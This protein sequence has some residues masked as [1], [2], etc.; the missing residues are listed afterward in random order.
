MDTTKH[1]DG[2]TLVVEGKRCPPLT[3]QPEQIT[4][5]ALESKGY[6]Q[7]QYEG[8]RKGAPLV[9]NNTLVSLP[10]YAG[11]LT[12]ILTGIQYVLAQA[13]NPLRNTIIR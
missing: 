6:N 5:D 2:S 11:Q 1:E 8:A 10:S 9:T 13:Q 4:I 3:L 7:V 12:A